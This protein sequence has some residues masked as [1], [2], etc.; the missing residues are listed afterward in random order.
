MALD[1][2][3]PPPSAERSLEVTRTVP[4]LAIFDHAVVKADELDINLLLRTEASI[5]G[6]KVEPIFISIWSSLEKLLQG[7]GN[8]CVLINSSF[9]AH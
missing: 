9:E 6:T 3:P 5:V 7:N 8:C 2:L 1:I 4:R